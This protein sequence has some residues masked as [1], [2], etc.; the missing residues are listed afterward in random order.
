MSAKIEFVNPTREHI[1][2]VA[3]HMRAADAR[4]VSLS[5]GH[6]PLQAIDKAYA[7]SRIC[8]IAT[9]DCVPAAAFGLV[10]GDPLSGIGSPWLLGTDAIFT[11]PRAMLKWG[12]V[13]VGIMHVHC[14]RLEN[15]VAA[16]NE[17]SIVWLKH[18]GFHF[19]EPAPY[20][21]GRAMFRKF[22]RENRRV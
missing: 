16:D 2:Y 15:Y 20:G 17:R 22:Y 11:Q 21:V 7:I 5:H 3:V 6:T 8:A 19:D 14:D 13:G 10:V 4:E 18:L 1:E 9:I 12:R